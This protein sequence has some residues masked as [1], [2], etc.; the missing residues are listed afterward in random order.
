MIATYEA[1]VT[2]IW[3]LSV[4]FGIFSAAPAAMFA[5]HMEN[6]K[7]WLTD[8]IALQH[9]WKGTAVTHWADQNEAAKGILQCLGKQ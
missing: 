2:H 4:I 7:N 1:T 8:N 9:T 3:R 5:T 6:I